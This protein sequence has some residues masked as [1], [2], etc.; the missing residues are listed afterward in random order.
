MTDQGETRPR[1]GAAST[2]GASGKTGRRGAVGAATR[3][4]A[5]RPG[6]TGGRGSALPLLLAIGGLSWGAAMAPAS[7]AAAQDAAPPAT[8]TAPMPAPMGPA[9][10][11]TAVT[12]YPAASPAAAVAPSMPPAGS[13]P[14]HPPT[15]EPAAMDC[16]AGAPTPALSSLVARMAAQPFRFGGDVAGT[17]PDTVA[18]PDRGSRLPAPSRLLIA[19]GPVGTDG[20]SSGDALL[21]DGARR[22]IATG[23]VQAAVNAAGDCRV[24]MAFS[25]GERAELDGTCRA[26]TI[27]GPLTLQGRRPGFIRRV[28]SWWDDRR[29]DGWAWMD[30]ASFDVP[31]RQPAG[32]CP[33]G[34]GTEIDG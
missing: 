15:T 21:M 4:T 9:P 25:D 1:G 19:L 6:R 8:G 3:G 30:R 31:F 20:R 10:A 26:D 13:G 32:V 14:A 7:L 17:L 5:N 29:V 18:D 33:V 22:L 12:G 28:A 2:D 34:P 11:A 23:T 27:S 24:S 16:T